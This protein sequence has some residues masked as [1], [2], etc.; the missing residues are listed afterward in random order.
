[1]QFFQPAMHY[2]LGDEGQVAATGESTLLYYLAAI[3][4][5]LFGP[6]EGWFRLLS[7]SILIGGLYVLSRCIWD[8]AHDVFYSIALPVL[9]FASPLIAFYAFNFVPNTPALGIVLMA[10][11]CLYSYSKSGRLF[12]F[13]GALLLFALA[14]L[15]KITALLAFVALGAI[16]LT[17]C[18]GWQRYGRAGQR[19]FRQGWNLSPA[20]LIPII[21]V[22]AWKVWAD[23]YN[24]LHQTSYFAASIKPIWA[25]EEGVRKYIFHRV[26]KFWSWDYFHACTHILIILL[27]LWTLLRPRRQHPFLFVLAW[28]LFI[29][30]LVYGLLWYKQFQ[31]HDYYA[32]D[33]FVYPITILTAALIYLK[34]Y[35]PRLIHAI[36]FKVVLTLFVFFNIHHARQVLDYRYTQSSPFMSHFNPSFYKQKELHAFLEEHGIRYPERVVS[37]PDSSPNSTLYHLNLKGWSELYMPHGISSKK[38]QSFINQGANYLIISNK[39]YLERE[40]LKKFLVKPVGVF[41]ESIYIYDLRELAGK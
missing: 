26:W 1:M 16:Y 2:M 3:L 39:D 24:A 8:I 9:I 20:F 17:E 4:Y 32:I 7:C 10:G 19:L 25:L 15:F 11:G 28:L 31:D 14:G 12:H 18:L 33:I 38:L 6:E 27:S 41:D 5:C 30:S 35:W 13:Y 34:K 40:N 23:Q 29:G 36:W 37:V 21:V 22:V